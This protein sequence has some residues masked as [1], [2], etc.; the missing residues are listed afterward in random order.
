MSLTVWDYGEEVQYE[1]SR[2]EL[3]DHLLCVSTMALDLYCTHCIDC[4]VAGVKRLMREAIE[5]KD[6]TPMFTAQPLEENL[7]EWHFTILG[8]Q[9][10]DYDSGRYHGRIILPTE[11]PMKP[12]SIIFLTVRVYLGEDQYFY[13]SHL[14][15]SRTG[16][17][18]Y[19]RRFAL[20]LLPTTLNCGSH[21]GAVS[22]VF[23]L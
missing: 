2:W 3:S 16:G 19:T 13:L 15:Y 10:T 20:V 22:T 6:P 4:T 18:S 7:F 12:P 23:I 17:L 9:G 1:E 14:E 11:Y 5:L 21:P 8:P